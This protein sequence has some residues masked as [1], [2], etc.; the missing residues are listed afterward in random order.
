MRVLCLEKN[1]FIGGMATTTE[2]ARGYRFELAGS[3]QFPIPT[4]IF[5]DLGFAACPIYEPEVQS[6]S[7]GPSAAGHR[8]CSTAIPTGS[9]SI[10]MSRSASKPCWAWPRSR[11]GLRPRPGPSGGWTYGSRQSH[12][13]RCGHAPPTR[14]SAWRSAPRCSEASWMSW[15]SFSPTARNT[16]RFAACSRFWRS[17][18]PTGARTRREVPSVSPLR[19]PPRATS[20]CPRSKVASAPCPTTYWDCSSSSGANSDDMSRSP[21]S[22]HPVSGS[23]GWPWPTGRS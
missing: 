7:I 1:H 10:S 22:S 6:A 14:R 15:T 20:P 11:P 13:T 23:R 19:W 5:D 16:P 4:E 12:S 9:S 8:S 3:I 21:E 2:L 18:P 17:I